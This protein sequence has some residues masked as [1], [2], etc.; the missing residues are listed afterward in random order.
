MS[1]I[2]ILNDLAFFFKC[3]KT[4]WPVTYI[5]CTGPYSQVYPSKEHFFT[6]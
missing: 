1:V 2:C 5:L 4:L 3:I 6:L